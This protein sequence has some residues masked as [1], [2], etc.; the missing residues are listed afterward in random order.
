MP[1][2]LE[3]RHATAV[4]VY[5]RAG[6]PA[7]RRGQ[8]RAMPTDPTPPAA[9]GPAPATRPRLAHIA[10][11]RVQPLRVGDHDE[12]SGIRKQRIDGP[13][14]VGPLGL[15]GDEQADLSVH[16]GPTRAV[17]A[18]PTVHRA[19]WQTVRAQAR[20]AEPG[21]PVP[22]GLFGE[23]IGIDGLDE[24]Q[25]WVGDRLVFP[26]CELAV[27][28]PRFPC[29]KFNAVMGFNQAAKLMTQ[30]GYCGTYLAVV[31]GGTMTAGQPFEVVPGPRDVGVRELFFARTRKAGV[32]S[33][34]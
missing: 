29:H 20:V 16:G 17:Y 22:P 27:S 30:S 18:Y 5:P 9:P 31:R 25:L 19:F 10:V 24:T 3:S 12:P 15:D 26:D 34:T 33:P 13:V 6:T 8:S 4:L 11:S 28:E 2:I 1:A 14:A 23:N 32:R 7:A 21:A